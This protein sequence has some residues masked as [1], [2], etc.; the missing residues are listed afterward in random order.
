MQQHVPCPTCGKKVPWVDE[1]T[2]KPFCNERCKLIDLGEWLTEK[3]SIP[4]E[5]ISAEADA[6][7]FE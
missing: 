5:S 7:L 2:F 4:G 6:N 1:H 3:N